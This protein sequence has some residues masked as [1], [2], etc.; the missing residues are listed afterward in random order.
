M[1]LPNKNIKLNNSLLGLGAILLPSLQFPTTVSELWTRVK[2][3]PSQT[4]SFEK[5]ILTLDFLYVIGLIELS[6][7]LIKRK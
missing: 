1:I 7:G 4:I 6:E 2:D 5:F 3:Y